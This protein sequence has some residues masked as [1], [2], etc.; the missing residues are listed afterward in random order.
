MGL[1]IH[2]HKVKAD[3]LYYHLPPEEQAGH[4][5][6]LQRMP[7]VHRLATMQVAGGIAAIGSPVLIVSQRTPRSP[8]TLPKP[9][10]HQ[11]ACSAAPTMSSVAVDQTLNPAV[12]TVKPSKTMALTDLATSMKEAGIDVSTF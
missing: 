1:Q 12:A 10:T 8:V 11:V 2:G 5:S 9:S 7:F 4:T 6:H 3:C